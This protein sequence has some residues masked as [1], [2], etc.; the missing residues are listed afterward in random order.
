MLLFYTNEQARRKR[1]GRENAD[2]LKIMQRIENLV[3][4]PPALWQMAVA[5]R[6]LMFARTW[7]IR[8][9]RGHIANSA[10]MAVAVIKLRMRGQVL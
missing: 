3:A 5:I 2:A 10:D 6:W 9:D 8:H 4:E 7:A 1:E